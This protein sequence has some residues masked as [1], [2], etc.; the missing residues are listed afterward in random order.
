MNFQLYKLSTY[1]IQQ[2]KTKK[3]M[4]RN[5][6]I[7]LIAAFIVIA[8]LLMFAQVPPHPNGGNAP[9]NGNGPVGGGAPVGSGL[10]ILIAMGAAYGA[11]KLYKMN[12]ATPAE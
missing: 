7:L 1:F 9:G 11:N 4:K 8:P 5:I 6:R 12:S 3:Y 2:L 10:I